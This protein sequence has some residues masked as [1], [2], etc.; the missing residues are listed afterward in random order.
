MT[1]IDEHLAQVAIGL[2]MSDEALLKAL[3]DTTEVLIKLGLTVEAK[4]LMA[5]AR[6]ERQ[7]EPPIEFWLWW[8]RDT[9]GWGLMYQSIEHG[10]AP[11][12]LWRVTGAHRSR[13]Q[14]AVQYLPALLRILAKNALGAAEAS[15]ALVSRLP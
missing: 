14:Y 15:K 4:V 5:D 13:Q 2:K 11:G 6:I 1:T 8:A 3:N 10:W 7:H 9:K 12:L